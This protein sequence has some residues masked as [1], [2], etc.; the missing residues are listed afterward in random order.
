L[1]PP[2]RT[3]PRPARGEDL[4]ALNRRLQ[5][6]VAQL[7]TLYHMG[8]DLAQNENWS[9]ALD[10]F[11]MMLV[12]FME[13]EGAALLL[14]SAEE[15]VLTPR[16]A[17]Q[18]DEAALERA[19]SA[20]LAGWSRHPRASEI[21][22]LE[23]YA[24]GGSARHFT[25]LEQTATWRMTVIPL[26]HRNKSL[27]FLLMEK[28][29]TN[30]R[31]FK[32]DFDF[33]NTL[34]TIF[35][36]EIA[37]ASYISELRQLSRF[38]NKVLDNI[39][40]GVISTDME[41]Y[42][43][44]A[45]VWACD[46]CPRLREAERV[47]VHFDTL[48]R[49]RQFPSDFFDGVVRSQQSSYLLE[50]ECDS[51]G[52]PFPARLRTTKMYD[53]NLNGTVVVAIFEDLTEQR[54]ME[55]EIRRND[56]LRALGQMSAGVAHEIRNPLTGIATTAEVLAGKIAGD[57]EKTRYVRAMLD[58]ISRLDGIIRNLLEFAR[59]PKPQIATCSLR[60]VAERVGGLL[61]E[62]AVGKGVRLEIAEVDPRLGC[63]ADSGQLT[64][65]LLNLVLNSLQACSEGDEVRV[66]CG[67]SHE[68]DGVARIDVTDTGPGIPEE[69]RDTL[70]DP[71]VTT[72]TR[73]TGLGL[74]IS[75]H[76]IEEHEG[77]IRCEFLDNGT[78]FSI[79]LPLG[80]PRA[81]KV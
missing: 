37:N 72:K 4:E 67:A 81:E 76:I 34:Q 71:F 79:E 62:Q 59:P 32:W 51:G 70:F 16:S 74:A 7:K 41:G 38:N 55:T 64:Q 47:S 30:G 44:Y 80:L 24:A 73:G 50:V 21:H 3:E 49:C 11:L 60:A 42:V 26:R 29:Y 5:R 46:M 23:S 9:D 39:R 14:F 31:V 66:E 45:N 63:M 77:T 25:C 33:L 18:I 10:R 1:P 8:H 57:E 12:G 27:G 28:P 35:A 36:E 56:R 53:D 20:I 78:R 43:R 52:E 48:F 22:S 69:I 19:C 13:A 15:A 54:R 17:F 2:I 40:S 6:V 61:S 75:Q 68:V 58:E 65:V